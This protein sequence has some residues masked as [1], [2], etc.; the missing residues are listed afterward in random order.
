MRKNVEKEQ[1]LFKKNKI[2]FL[3][4]NQETQGVLDLIQE[5]IKEEEKFYLFSS[6]VKADFLY[7]KK[8]I[9]STK[10]NYFQIYEKNIYHCL[11]KIKKML[12]DSC[13]KYEINIDKSM[14]YVTSSYEDEF[15]PEYWYDFGGIKIPAFCGYWFLD[16][17]EESYIDINGEKVNIENG[18]VIMFE[19]GYRLSFSGVNSAISFNINTLS[20]IKNQ[21]PQKWMPIFL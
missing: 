19:P 2:F 7:E 18:T 16:V 17:E 8:I 15:L 1:L 5:N 14:Y 21:Y 4:D 6:G 20:K 12:E 11:K 9:D 3:I 10:F 13:K